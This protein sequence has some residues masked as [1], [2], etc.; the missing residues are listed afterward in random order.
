MECRHQR[1]DPLENPTSFEFEGLR[2]LSVTQNV[3]ERGVCLC[4][5][6]WPEPFVELI[7]RAVGL[8]PLLDKGP[9]PAPPATL[10]GLL[11]TVSRLLRQLC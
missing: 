9:F 7:T 6:V 2:D 8:K 10:L 11:S 5:D 3:L 1:A 4:F